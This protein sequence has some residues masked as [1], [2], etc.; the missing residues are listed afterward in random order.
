MAKKTVKKDEKKKVAPTISPKVDVG[1]PAVRVGEEISEAELVKQAEE[2]E[3]ERKATEDIEH[4]EAKKAEKEAK[5]AEKAAHKAERSTHRVQPLHG[6]KYRKLAEKIEKDKEYPIAEA[7]ALAIET[8]P[9][10]FDATVE[11]HIKVNIKEK[12]IRGMVVLPGGV[13]K[14]KKVLEVTESNVDEV[15]AKVKANKIEFDIMLADMKVMPKLAVLAKVLG[16][17][18][19]MPS[20]KAGTVVPDVKKAADELHGGKVEYRADKSNIINMAIGRISFGPEKIHQNFS[21]IMDRLPKRIDSIHLSTSMGP[22]VKVA[23]K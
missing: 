7:I 16:P 18:G 11:L 17:K 14:E 10:K 20:P 23:R 4:E 22:S 8:N 13:T 3:K 21:A 2:R 15:I 5:K 19:L 6:K 9:A 12:N 1:V